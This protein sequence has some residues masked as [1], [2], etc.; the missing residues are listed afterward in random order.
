MSRNLAFDPFQ[1]DSKA[2]NDF[3]AKCI[4]YLRSRKDLQFNTISTE[5]SVGSVGSWLEVRLRSDMKNCI[6][7]PKELSLHII[8]ERA[9]HFECSY[10]MLVGWAFLILSD[11]FSIH[12]SKDRQLAGS[13]AGME[14][15]CRDK[16]HNS[17]LQIAIVSLVKDLYEKSKLRKFW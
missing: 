11:G 7:L 10:A 15:S 12:N 13:L 16:Q 9:K 6:V 3:I 1:I 17:K 8:A 5:D 4:K 2:R 14:A